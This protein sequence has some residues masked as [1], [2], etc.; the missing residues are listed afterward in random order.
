MSTTKIV[1]FH[2]LG[3]ADVLKIEEVPLEEPKAD[4]VRLKVEAI[5][6]NRAEVAY[7]QG[8]YMEQPQF[9]S[10]IGVEAAGTVE[11]VGANVTNV[12]IGDRVGVI[13]SFS[14]NQ[15]GTYGETIIL[16]AIALV[17]TPENVTHIEAAASWV[18]YLTGYFALV[19]VGKVQAGQHILITAASSSTGFAAIELVKLL[20]AKSIATTRTAAKKQ[21]LLDAGADYVI[22]TQEENI[23]ERVMEITNGKG[24]ELIYDPIAGSTLETLAPAAAIGGTI[25]LYGFLD[26]SPTVYPLMTAFARNFLLRTYAVYSFIGAPGFGIPRNEEAFA[27][28]VKFISDHLA[29][30]TLK[31]KIAKTFPFSEIQDAH[32]FMESNQ[33]SGKIVVTV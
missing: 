33:Q 31:P 8:Q 6:L 30:G 23:A 14:Q 18:Q 21:D 16:P 10:R 27:R 7:R 28:G 9:P 17:P 11:A 29:S 19:D 20:G 24:A 26:S 3:S 22:V 13:A 5:G 15:Y 4:E 2:E 32:R 1:R 12:K 25:L